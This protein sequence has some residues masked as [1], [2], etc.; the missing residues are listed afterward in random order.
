M[1]RKLSIIGLTVLLTSC[2]NSPRAPDWVTAPN[3]CS[4]LL[5]GGGTVTPEQVVN[6]NWFKINSALSSKLADRLEAMNYRINRLIVDVRDNKARV[7]A[8]SAEMNKTQCNKVI[9]VSH[10]LTSSDQTIDGFQFEVSI[11]G[12]APNSSGVAFT[13][14]Y[15]KVYKFRMTREVMES[16]SMSALAEQMATELDGSR[17]LTKAGDQ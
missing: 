1:L 4:V 5:G 10:T 12:V 2:A 15:K 13:G 6:A 11:L 9:Q 8:A 17:L 14:E 16:L 7:Q 3:R